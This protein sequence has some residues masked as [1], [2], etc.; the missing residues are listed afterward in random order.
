[1]LRGGRAASALAAVEGILSDTRA[2]ADISV[3]AIALRLEGSSLLQL[4]RRDDAVAAFTESIRAAEQAGVV[5]EQA[6]AL[7]GLA[8][9]SGDAEPATESRRLLARL[10]VESVAR[11]SLN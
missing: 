6:L 10:A 3:R 7:D 5:Y 1:V 2:A 9:A 11:P 8:S 4:G